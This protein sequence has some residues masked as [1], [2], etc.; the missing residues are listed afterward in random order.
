M[1]VETVVP[2][3]LNLEGISKRFGGIRA[4]RDGRLRIDRPGTVHGLIGENGSGKST[5]LGVLSG[6]VRPDEGSLQVD[7]KPVNFLSP[8][9][10]L[11]TGIA[12]VSQETA[13]A[14]MLS[15]TENILLGHRLVRGRTGIDWPRSHE[16]ASSI[17]D[18][19]GLDYDPR[20]LVGTLRPDRRQMVEIARALSMDSRVLILDEPTSS[21]SEDGV[22]AIFQVIRNLSTGGVSTIL[23]THRLSELF[24]ICDDLTVL[25]DGRTV[26]SGAARSFNADTLV[27]AMVGDSRAAERVPRGKSS[28]RNGQRHADPVLKLSAVSSA[29]DLHNVDL[30]LYRGEIV[31]LAGLVGAGRSD[32]L[33][34][35]FGSRGRSGTVLI[36][37]I[38][39]A[40]DH[41]SSSISRGIGYVPPDR[42]TGG[43]ILGMSVFDNL[44][45]VAG[46]SRF[47]G[48]PPR[49]SRDVVATRR[50]SESVRIRAN[51]ANVPVGT[52]SGGNQQ[53]V[54]LGKW[55][56]NPPKVLLLDEPSRGVDV[57]AKAEIHQILTELADRGVA[58]LVSSSEN[59]ELLTICDRIAVMLHGRIVAEVLRDEAD[60]ALLS[61]LAGG[62]LDH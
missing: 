12:M 55:L 54:A 15:V 16:R 39:L 33:E 53:K 22:S 17:L 45:M 5:I 35:V 51:G 18:R 52:L 42:K 24:E 44:M 10:A 3:L 57:A 20:A 50:V 23:V 27:A 4:L 48:S 21:L 43:V 38:P 19:L 47:R 25:R 41:P 9:D 56:V 61:G 32:L 30:S 46:S 26:A 58:L 29:P 37:G 13:L 49:T 28:G 40:S 62:H 36:D 1:T 2:P 7:G 59:D 60:E 31:G 6:Q 14:P 34:A 11:R 8:V